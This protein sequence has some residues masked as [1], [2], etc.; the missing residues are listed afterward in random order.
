MSRV[1][2]AGPGRVQDVTDNSGGNGDEG[3]N[4]GDDALPPAA[5]DPLTALRN[6]DGSFAQGDGWDVL[7]H[8]MHRASN[9]ILHRRHRKM[10]RAKILGDQ[11]MALHADWAKA[12][13]EVV[14]DSQGGYQLER[15][16]EGNDG[17]SHDGNGNEVASANGNE[18]R[19][20]DGVRTWT[21]NLGY[22]RQTIGNGVGEMGLADA[23]GVADADAGEQEKGVTNGV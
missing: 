2:I 7:L 4:A 6:P 5:L 12:A 18:D 8:Q 3:Q 11:C 23:D 21:V 13:G 22:R 19:N 20:E 14:S 1:P 16:L 15:T 10:R 9:A 17:E